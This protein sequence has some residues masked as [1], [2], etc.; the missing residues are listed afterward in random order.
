LSRKPQTRHEACW[1]VSRITW[2]CVKSDRD[3]HLVYTRCGG[4]V[5]LAPCERWPQRKL[6]VVGFDW[7]SGHGRCF[8]G[9]R[10]AEVR[11]SPED[12]RCPPAVPISRRAWT[13][14]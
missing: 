9:P 7:L 8:A 13:V 5:G 12:L 10:L 11:I 1:V 14:S 3:Q 6:L 2:R 4:F